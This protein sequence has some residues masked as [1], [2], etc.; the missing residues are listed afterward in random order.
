MSLTIHE[1]FHGFIAD[2]LG[3]PTSRMRGRLSLNP[4]AHLDPL[5]TI[6]LLVAGFGWAKPVPVDAFNF[7]DPKRDMALVALAGPASNFIIA[8]VFAL[9]FRL[10]IGQDTIFSDVF[11]LLVQ[12]NLGL[13]IFNFVPVAPLDGSKIIMLFL[14]N[15]LAYEYENFMHQYGFLILL[16]LIFPWY[17][18]TSP[19][20][21]LIGP[22]IQLAMQVLL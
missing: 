17:Q 8:I 11:V 18:G 4:L 6:M 9:L 20:S 14:R 1:F 22:V 16:A 7:K 19:I 2:K 21:A 13:G 10:G 5:G 15:D 12:I 3:D